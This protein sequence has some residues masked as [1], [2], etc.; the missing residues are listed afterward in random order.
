MTTPKTESTSWRLIEEKS[1]VRG[2]LNYVIHDP[3]KFGRVANVYI[4][5]LVPLLLNAP[6][7]LEALKEARTRIYNDNVQSVIPPGHGVEE[8]VE[9]YAADTL[10]LIDSAIAQA[11]GRAE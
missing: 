9:G 2:F 5:S 8:I 11:E 3:G 6:A 10:R 7:L 1:D 4:P